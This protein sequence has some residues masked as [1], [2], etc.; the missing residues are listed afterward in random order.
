MLLTLVLVGI[1]VLLVCYISLD[2][3]LTQKKE[4][5]MMKKHNEQ[6]DKLLKKLMA[7]DFTDYATNQ[8]YI[9]NG[10]STAYLPKDELSAALTQVS[11]QMMS[12]EEN[13]DV[14][15]I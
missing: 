14:S 12:E 4:L 3:I 1:I 10:P 6:M 13:E 7:R 2:R 9:E 5:E 15:I 8:H 11:Q